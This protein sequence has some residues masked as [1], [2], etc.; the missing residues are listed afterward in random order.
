[1]TRSISSLYFQSHD[2][3]AARIARRIEAGCERATSQPLVFFRADDIAIP[4]RSFADFIA[5]FRKYSIPLCLA[6]V[7]T[8]LNEK[9]LAELRLVTGTT[10]GTSSQW[11]WHQHGYV[12][13]NFEPSGKKQEFGPARGPAELRKSLAQGQDRLL[14][15]LGHDFCPVFTPPWN[16]CGEAT[17]QAL[18]DLGFKAVSRSSGA[19][20][21][22]PAILPDFQV[23]V[24]LH[25]RKEPSPELAFAA[26]LNELEDSL[27]SG[28]CGIMIHHQRMN[29]KALQ[30]LDDLLAHI[31]NHR[32][33]VPVHF[34]D[35]LKEIS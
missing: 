24:D 3:A 34:G 7:P 32:A 31:K 20:P 15:L 14:R 35:L 29:A 19:R 18:A 1:M 8:W 6:T 9:R 10:A 27:A 5:L 26:L 21:A 13:H 23:Q 2:D 4:S 12:H 25:T 16:R 30:L 17:L 28:R 11:C 33:I 22:A